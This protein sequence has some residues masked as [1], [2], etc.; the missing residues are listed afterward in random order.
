MLMDVL[1]TPS[2]GTPTPDANAASK[3]A[4]L[5][6]SKMA[7]RGAHEVVL[8][9][10]YDN[11]PS[12]ALYDR[13]GFLREKRLHRFY[14]NH[15]DAFRLIL[16]IERDQPPPLESEEEADR[17]RWLIGAGSGPGSDL[18]KQ[19]QGS[20]YYGHD[21]QNGLGN[22]PENGIYEVSSSHPQSQSRPQPYFYDQ[23][24]EMLSTGT[25]RPT[26]KELEYGMYI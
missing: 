23:D 2:L 16:P 19:S 22:I 17:G 9:T 20:G 12:L 5:A 10:E 1:H 18:L 3:L 6:I 25:P 7:E 14:S 11:A 21:T 24:E 26:A 4:E 13:L 8:E 15:K